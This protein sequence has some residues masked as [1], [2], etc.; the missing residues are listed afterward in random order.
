M[1]NEG[2]DVFH[3][4]WHHLLELCGLVGAC[5]VD[6]DGSYDPGDP[7]DRLLLGLKG[8]MSE[9]ELTLLRKRML[10]A[11]S[12]KARRGELRVLVPIGYVWSR[13]TGLM[14]D[15][16]RRVQEAIHTVF[17]L[18]ERLGSARR[19]LLHLW[20]E[21]ISVPRSADGR[22]LRRLEWRAPVYRSVNAVLRNPF[23]AGAY[24]YGKSRVETTVVDGRIRKTYGRLR[25]MPSWKVLI[26]EH[27]EGYISWEQFEQNQRRLERNAFRKPAG[28]AKS[29]RGGQALLAGLLRC[30]RCG[31]M[32][33]VHYQS[34]G[35]HRYACRMG[36]MWHGAAPCIGF[37]AHH[38]DEAIAAEI[39]LAVQP[40]A[41]E[42][43]LVA[44]RE[45]MK[46]GDERRRALELEREQAEY[47]VKLAARRY[48]AVDPDNRLVAGEL[49]AR[50]NA[51]LAR[52]REC[53]TRL[54]DDQETVTASVDR[55]T[56]LTLATDLRVAW[57]AA[58]ADMRT[59]QRLV[60][61]L[62]EEIVVDV[63][64]AALEVVLVIHWRGGQHSEVRAR[65]TSRGHHERRAS[66]DADRVIREMAVRWSDAAIATTLNRMGLITGQ[67]NTWNAKRVAS[68]RREAAIAGPAPE[69]LCLTMIEAADRLGV[70]RHV[71]KRLVDDGVLPATQV[72]P[73]AP[74]Q[75]RACDLDLPAIAAALGARRRRR[76]RPRRGDGDDR[77]LLLPG[78]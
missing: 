7:N 33:T 22:T 54:S 6:T 64:E 8:T 72:A 78:N 13:E 24:A 57:N 68:R 73:E 44:E 29:G 45:A 31:R 15:P 25:P 69:M 56:L 3:C 47:E 65:K 10:D 5:V 27:H 55:E 35:M 51:A 70:S 39:L 62:V 49:E 40:L 16:D 76:G 28:S 66:E 46:Q 53:E 19:V 11:L 50:W 59:K 48:E 14:M 32:L 61:T 71:V 60:R 58:G 30:R 9:F 23:Y 74:W 12:A 36:S 43:A 4:I 18:F 34:R 75:I 41:V 67:G 21:K 38:P 77:S 52:L 20:R 63:D 17:R 37:A 2:E 26:R 42:A 1:S